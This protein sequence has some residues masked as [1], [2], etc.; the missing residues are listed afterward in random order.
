MLEQAFQMEINKPL[1]IHLLDIC[2]VVITAASGGL[3]SPL[4]ARQKHLSF[5][6]RVSAKRLLICSLFIVFVTTWF[7]RS[8]L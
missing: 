8:Y 5:R 1:F 3:M 7:I 6:W 4:T 2:S